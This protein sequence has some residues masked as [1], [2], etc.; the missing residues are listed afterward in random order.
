MHL[1]VENYSLRQV[2]TC[3]IHVE[4]CILQ[5]DVQ[6]LVLR[7]SLFSTLKR[8]A[9]VHLL[10]YFDFFGQTTCT[11]RASREVNEAIRQSHGDFEWEQTFPC[12]QN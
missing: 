10:G 8:K 5:D 7:Y 12:F 11:L 4:A 9:A 1:Y 2:A 6:V 3:V